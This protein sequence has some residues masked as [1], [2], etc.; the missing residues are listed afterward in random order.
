MGR[1]QLKA[2]IG[3]TGRY[4]PQSG[5]TRGVISSDAYNWNRPRTAKQPIFSGKIISTGT[6]EGIVEPGLNPGPTSWIAL[7][8]SRFREI[9]GPSTRYGGDDILHCCYE[10][11]AFLGAEDAIRHKIL[12]LINE[13]K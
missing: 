4:W 12:H 1:L 10:C 7:S 6:I 11:G 5:H 9:Q 3:V 8:G 2:I 13:G